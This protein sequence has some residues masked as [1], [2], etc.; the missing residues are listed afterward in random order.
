MCVDWKPFCLCL[1]LPFF[2][3]RIILLN[4]LNASCEFCHLLIWKILIP[5]FIFIYLY[6]SIQWWELSLKYGVYAFLDFNPFFYVLSFKV[7]KSSPFYSNNIPFFFEKKKFWKRE[8]SFIYLFAIYFLLKAWNTKSSKKKKKNWLINPKI[9]YN[10]LDRILIKE[11]CSKW[12][13][14]RS[15]YW[16]IE[17]YSSPIQ[18]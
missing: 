5:I 9:I 12:T 6:N 16:L 1:C 2:N 8:P 4:L 13:I 11:K 3:I 17:Y 10:W 14:P 15:S 18:I 7:E